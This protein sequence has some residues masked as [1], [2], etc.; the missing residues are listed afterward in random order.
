MATSTQT[1][2]LP[3]AGT[4][5]PVFIMPLSNDPQPKTYP[6]FSIADVSNHNTGASI[7]IIAN[8]NV[9]DVTTFSD[10]H[11]G[12]KKSLYSLLLSI[13]AT[14][15]FWFLFSVDLSV[16]CGEVTDNLIVMQTVAGKDATKQVNKYHR[17]MIIK[18]HEAQLKVG[19]VI[20]EQPKKSIGRLFGFGKK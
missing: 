17:P 19:E 9:Y 10:D 18:R 5:T 12:G 4:P 13:K 6:K 16:V 15:S 7:W 8:G 20:A 11:P 3:A 14:T 2:T 1:S